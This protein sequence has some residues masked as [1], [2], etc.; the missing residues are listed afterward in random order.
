MPLSEDLITGSRPPVESDAA[1]AWQPSTLLQSL[2]WHLLPAQRT[3]FF[4]HT[5][6]KLPAWACLLLEPSLSHTNL[7]SDVSHSQSAFEFL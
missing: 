1:S 3:N 5:A 6:L 7:H 4:L 2:P